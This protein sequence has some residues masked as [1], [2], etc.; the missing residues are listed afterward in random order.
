MA[1]SYM[2]CRMKNNNKKGTQYFFIRVHYNESQT[3]WENLFCEENLK[4][5]NIRESVQKGGKYWEAICFNSRRS[6]IRS[7]GV[8]KLV[9]VLIIVE[10]VY[11]EWSRL[12][13]PAMYHK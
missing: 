3:L 9:I 12:L 5:N 13:L 6:F 8:Y 4:A 11:V 7:S 2:F 10:S 1:Y